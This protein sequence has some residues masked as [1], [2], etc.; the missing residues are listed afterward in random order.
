MREEK[1]EAKRL[2]GRREEKQEATG[3]KERGKAGGH[4]KE[5]ERKS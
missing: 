1:L 2:E 3:R 4:W 5:G